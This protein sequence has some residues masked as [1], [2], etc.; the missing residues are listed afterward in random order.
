MHP[1]KQFL[2]AFMSIL[3]TWGSL[4]IHA[5]VFPPIT[6]VEQVPRQDI[7][8]PT[9]REEEAPLNSKGEKLLWAQQT[10]NTG[11]ILLVLKQVPQGLPALVPDS[12]WLPVHFPKQVFRLMPLCIQNILRYYTAPQA[13]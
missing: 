11:P 4:G 10:S 9:D 5:V 12:V 13:P 2:L 7:D 1:A 8:S 6:A 3:I